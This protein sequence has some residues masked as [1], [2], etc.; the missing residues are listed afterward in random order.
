M[1]WKLPSQFGL[2]WF[3]GFRGEDWNMKVYNVQQTQKWW[4]GDS[5]TYGGQRYLIDDLIK[6]TRW[7]VS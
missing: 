2:I 4:P 1:W 6:W 3:S 5:K 7:T